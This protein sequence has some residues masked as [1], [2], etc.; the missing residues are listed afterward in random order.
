MPD[1]MDECTYF[2]R[3]T[4]D[5]VEIIAWVK[6]KECPKCKAR[7]GKPIKKNGKVD[8][9]ADYYECPKCKYQEPNQE[10]EESLNVEI[11]YT[12]PHCGNKGETKTEYKLK[13][14]KG[15]KA[16]IFTCQKCNEKIPVTKKMKAIKKKK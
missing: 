16:Y 15:T 13:P 1:S 11:I 7:M 8:K 12:C 5:N 14:F 9:K 2:T 3:R 6:R 4:I 10:H